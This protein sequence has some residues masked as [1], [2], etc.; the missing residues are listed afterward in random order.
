MKSLRKSIPNTAQLRDG[1]PVCVSV[2]A[3]EPGRQAATHPAVKCGMVV[4]HVEG[5]PVVGLDYMDIEDIML[6]SR[7]FIMVPRQSDHFKDV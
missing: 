5:E 3:I 6:G 1:R 4:T 2:G 7:R